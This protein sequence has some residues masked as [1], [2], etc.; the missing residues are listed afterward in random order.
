MMYMVRLTGHLESLLATH[1]CVVI[2]GVGG[3]V[4]Q[5]VPSVHNEEEHT[6]LPMRREIGFNGDLTHSDGLLTSSYA[7]TYGKEFEE[8]QA[9]LEEDIFELR[10]TL[11]RCD[12]VSLGSLGTLTLGEEGQPVFTPGDT[13]I[14]SAD[15]YG[16][17]PFAVPPLPQE[18]EKAALKRKKAAHVWLNGKFVRA[19]AVAVAIAAAAIV[20]PLTV[21]DR[22]ADTYE[23]AVIPTGTRD[24]SPAKTI[25][26][27][28]EITLPAAETETETV[29][30]SAGIIKK[31]AVL[32]KKEIKPETKPAPEK[33][34]EPK[35][36]PASTP[37]AVS[38]PK[39]APKAAVSTVA[40]GK[41][42]VVIGSFP[43]EK[44]ASA[45]L[46]D[47][48]KSSGAAGTGIVHRNGKFRIYAGNYA[49]RTDAQTALYQIRRTAHHKDAWLFI[50][51]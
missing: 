4:V 20:I 26:P 27:E 2:P 31:E 23:A 36:V 18:K 43:E 7:S 46:A 40:G 24:V 38:T 41:Y 1:D 21:S 10:S 51:K 12:K 15:T 35:A 16:L 48:R 50:D 28:P 9:I 25:Q 34:L 32:S 3:F 30:E 47:Y 17:A 42:Y 5:K 19:V 37:A 29:N 8:A 11:E 33:K 6:F 44:T 13:D 49:S 39:P 14:F 22:E 45:A